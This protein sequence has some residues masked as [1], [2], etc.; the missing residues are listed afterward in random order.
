[1]LETRPLDADNASGDAIDAVD[2]MGDVWSVSG[3]AA[4]DV[5]PAV[6]VPSAFAGEMAKLLGPM[7][8]GAERVAPSAAELAGVVAPVPDDAP[9][10]AAPSAAS[11]LLILFALVAAALPAP[12]GATTAVGGWLGTVT[13]C[14]V[15]AARPLPATGGAVEA[16]VVDVVEESD[17]FVP[18]TTLE[19]PAS[20]A[21]GGVAP[22]TA[23]PCPDEAA[24]LPEELGASA[25]PVVA[26]A[27][28]TWATDGTD[29]TLTLTEGTPT[30]GG[31]LI[32]GTAGD[33][34]PVAVGWLAADVED[35]VA[36]TPEALEALPVD[37]VTW[38][39]VVAPVVALLGGWPLAWSP[40]A[41]ADLCR[42][43]TEAC[44]AVS[45]ARL[46]VAASTCDTR[47]DGLVALCIA[48]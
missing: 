11:M 34:A 12:A 47:F 37:P 38:G 30:C 39:A 1:M 20:G 2:R 26:G 22:V 29:G 48:T 25:P 28:V 41:A 31:A 3:C 6:L 9:P 18:A 27:M 23:P 32:C 45:L 10:G 13:A 7:S 5:A 36:A 33:G 43:C 19:D 16:D 35:V 4:G 24:D 21:S 40:F 17:G 15:P 42:G 44:A 14:V 46:C 8:A